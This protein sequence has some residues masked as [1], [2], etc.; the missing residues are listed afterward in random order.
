MIVVGTPLVVAGIFIVN[1][2]ENETFPFLE[3]DTFDETQSVKQAYESGLEF[4]SS[5]YQFQNI[6]GKV[7]Y[8]NCVNLVES[9][10]L[11]NSEK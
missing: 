4:C 8:E 2:V 1:T 10:Y 6:K 11:E 5:K 7:E 9:W 3:S